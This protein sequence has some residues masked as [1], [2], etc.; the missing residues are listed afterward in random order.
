MV[1]DLELLQ[2]QCYCPGCEAVYLRMV[3]SGFVNSRWAYKHDGYLV[4]YHDG[5]R[6][7]FRGHNAKLLQQL[8]KGGD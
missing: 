4:I 8:E 1:S 2:V 6:H 7:G 3:E 5:C